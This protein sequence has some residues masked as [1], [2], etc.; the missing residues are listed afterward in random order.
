MIIESY[1]V[2]RYILEGKY[3]IIQNSNVAFTKIINPIITFKKVNCNNK[4]CVYIK[5]NSGVTIKDVIYKECIKEDFITDVFINGIKKIYMNI[6]RG[7]RIGTMKSNQIVIIE[8]KNNTDFNCK[9]IISY[10]FV[11]NNQI[12]NMYVLN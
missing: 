9:S 7:I 5:N 11:I 3:I 8:Y 2:V 4:I 10:N 12:N 1:A 6:N